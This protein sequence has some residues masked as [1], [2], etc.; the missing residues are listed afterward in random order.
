MIIYITVN[1]F[2]AKIP[3]LYPQRAVKNLKVLISS[4]GIEI[5]H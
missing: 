2:Q 1:L 3:F 5:E 4:G